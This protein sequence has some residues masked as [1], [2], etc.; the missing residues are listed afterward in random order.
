MGTTVENNQTGPHVSGGVFKGYA[1]HAHQAN[2]GLDIWSADPTYPQLR[3][4]VNA[5]RDGDDAAFDVAG[6]AAYGGAW[7]AQYVVG[8]GRRATVRETMRHYLP[9]SIPMPLP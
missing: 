4:V 7:W 2:T 6:A 9:L 3:A 8:A 1:L 5:A